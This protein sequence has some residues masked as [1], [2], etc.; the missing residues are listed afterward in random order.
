MSRYAD[1]MDSVDRL[2]VYAEL[3]GFTGKDMA[4]IGGAMDRKKVADEAKH[5]VKRVD[6]AFTF[7]PFNE[8]RYPGSVYDRWK[9]KTDNGEYHFNMSY[10]SVAIKSKQ[11]K[12]EIEV[13]PSYYTLPK[14]WSWGKCL[15][16]SVMLDILNGKTQL[17]F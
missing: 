3:L 9:I 14:H 8:G 13:S 10:S 15:R 7:L 2:M 1:R 5:N 17:N 4:A 12:Q 16:Y 6:D 11:T